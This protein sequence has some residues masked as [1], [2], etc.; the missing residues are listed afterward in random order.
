MEN[1]PSPHNRSLTITSIVTKEIPQQVQL[2]K[3]YNSD[4][5][6]AGYVFKNNCSSIQ[7]SLLPIR[8]NACSEM[9]AARFQYINKGNAPARK[10]LFTIALPKAITDVSTGFP[11]IYDE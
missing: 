6:A 4:T 9:S 3:S 1:I 11:M 7:S 2:V 8:S 5:I 10:V